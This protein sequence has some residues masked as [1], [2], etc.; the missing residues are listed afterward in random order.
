[1]EVKAVKKYLRI[2]PTK[3]RLVARSIKSLPVDKAMGV[4]QFTRKGSAKPMTKLLKS[5]IAN[6]KNNFG[7]SEDNLYVKKVLVDQAPTLKRFQPRAQGR[8]FSIL[9][10]SSHITLVLEEK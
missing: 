9:K 1:M 10:R 4:L 7:L 8:A 5:A 6:A 2:S 3:V